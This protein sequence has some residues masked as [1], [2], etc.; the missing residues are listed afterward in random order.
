M[1]SFLGNPIFIFLS[2]IDLYFSP[3]SPQQA[4]SLASQGGTRLVERPT[5]KAK[6]TPVRFAPQ[7][8]WGEGDWFRPELA[9]GR[10]KRAG[11][12]MVFG[13]AGTTL[14]GQGAWYNGSGEK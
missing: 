10:K 5:P 7:P 1:R 8:R 13:F 12:S 3:R 14:T 4:G 6:V 9:E 11:V 2:V